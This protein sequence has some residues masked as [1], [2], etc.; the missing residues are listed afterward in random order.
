MGLPSVAN[1]FSAASFGFF[2]YMTHGLLEMASY[3]VAGLAGG[4]IS[5]ALIKHNFKN[6][7]VFIDV[8]DLIFISVGLIIIAGIVEVY[9]TPLLF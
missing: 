8:I 1:Y 2:R 5:I 4:I 6:D 3:F 9:I 7:R